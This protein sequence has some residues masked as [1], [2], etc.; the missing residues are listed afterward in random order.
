MPRGRAVAGRR[1]P[2]RRPVVRG[3]V[4]WGAAGAWEAESA[5]TAARRPR[6]WSPPCAVCGRIALPYVSVP[7]RR[8]LSALPA[9]GLRRPYGNSRRPN[10]GP[11]TGSYRFLSFPAVKSPGRSRGG[12]TGSRI[13]AAMPFTLSHAAAV[14]PGIRRSG[15]GRGP[16]VASAL[17]A[18]SFA[19]D[20]TY[21]ADTVVPGAM[22]F[23]E[24]THAAWGV[25]T[26]DVLI[27]G[28]PGGTVADA[29]RSPRRVAARG[30][31]GACARL[32]AGAAPGARPPGPPRGGVVRRVRRHRLGYPC[33]VGRLHAS[34][35]VGHGAGPRA[36][37]GA[38]RAT[39]C[40]RSSSTAV[41]PW[42]WRSWRGSRTRACG[43]PGPLPPP[44]SVPV[45]GRTE[46]DGPGRSS[47]S[48]S[49][50]ASSTGVPAGTPTSGT[51]T[52]PSTSS[53]PRASAPGRAWR[54][55]CCCT[56]RGCG[57]CAGRPPRPGR[58]T[59]PVRTPHG[60]PG[61][62]ASARR[63]RPPDP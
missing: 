25:F 2:G 56:G 33:R 8:R 61:R 54:P 51:S 53:R 52:R 50:W 18:G 48:A 17:V 29:A 26:V 32:R 13:L 19:P 21:Y 15:T 39:R 63:R 27:T 41:R 6:W 35:P 10:T 4:G 12:D 45:L 28:R 31:A 7:P 30:G 23:G 11:L 40:S 49:C 14:L 20:M 36:S 37:T 60:Q 16:L 42:P 3:A 9:R 22:E 46:R 38:S 24:V 62:P 57:S 55:A 47:G 44:A 1:R 34:R 59:R 43:A 5:A 58:R